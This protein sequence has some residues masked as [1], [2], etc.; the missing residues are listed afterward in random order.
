MRIN[1]NSIMMGTPF[2]MWSLH[3]K[4]ST[5]RLCLGKLLNLRAE[6]PFDSEG[7]E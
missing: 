5:V 4:L 6:H 1:G 2:V 3:C 7:I